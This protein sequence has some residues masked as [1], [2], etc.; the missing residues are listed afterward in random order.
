M[1]HLSS[2]S[3]LISEALLWGNYGPKQWLGRWSQNCSVVDTRKLA[4]KITCTYPSPLLQLLSNSVY[5]LLSDHLER[6]RWAATRPKWSVT[7]IDCNKAKSGLTALVNLRYI[8]C[9]FAIV[10]GWRLVHV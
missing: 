2:A 7:H 3:S 9:A 10:I 5:S 4:L 1:Y 8:L 6:L